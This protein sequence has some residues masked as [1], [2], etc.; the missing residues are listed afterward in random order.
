MR[1]FLYICRFTYQHWLNKVYDNEISIKW[2][3]LFGLKASYFGVFMISAQAA[4]RRWL[5]MSWRLTGLDSWCM[6][7][8]YILQITYIRRYSWLVNFFSW[9][10]TLEKMNKENYIKKWVTFYNQT[11][12][13]LLVIS[14]F[15]YIYIYI[16]MLNKNQLRECL[17]TLLDRFKLRYC[18]SFRLHP[19]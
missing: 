16:R 18:W 9:L 15:I 17:T 13:L 10:K 3:I 7:D 1:I 2:I 11:N 14:H 19:K 6:R 8:I 4:Q 5:G 12:M